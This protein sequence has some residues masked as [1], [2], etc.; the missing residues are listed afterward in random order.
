MCEDPRSTEELIQAALAVPA[1]EHAHW[2]PVA[3]LHWRGTREVFEAAETLCYSESVDERCLGTDILAQL[4]AE[5][6]PFREEA[7][8]ILM[9]LLDD[10]D[11]RVVHSAG[12]ALGHHGDARAVGPLIAKAAHPSAAARY[13]IGRA[14][15]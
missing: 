5:T 8:P 6:R 11:E 9:R 15:V 10:A 12:I 2:E 13:E 3:V 1:D 7:L 14:H 4:G